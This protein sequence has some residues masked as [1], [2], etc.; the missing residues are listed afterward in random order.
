MCILRVHVHTETYL[1]FFPNGALRVDYSRAAL[2]LHLHNLVASREKNRQEM[3]E[4]TGWRRGF[5]NGQQLEKV[6][7]ND[8]Y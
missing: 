7:S 2:E 8:W 4:R 3:I 5:Q 1:G 6:L